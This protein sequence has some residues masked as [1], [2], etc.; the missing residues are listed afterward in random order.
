[1]DD[2]KIGSYSTQRNKAVAMYLSGMSASKAA[3]A[4]PFPRSSLY[5]YLRF[6]NLMRKG[7]QSYLRMEW[8]PSQEEIEIE[9]AKIRATWSPAVMGQR[10]VGGGGS[11]RV[12]QMFRRL[13]KAVRGAA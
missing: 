9:T 10:W 2:R 13:G 3:D 7:S 12:E 6:A 5:D 8:V 4:A 11:E 1:M